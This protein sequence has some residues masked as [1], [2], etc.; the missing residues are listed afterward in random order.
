MPPTRSEWIIAKREASATRG[1][2]TAD[3][4]AAADAGL[5]V[6]REGGNAV[7]AAVTAAF[8]MGVAEPFTSG[9][10]GVACMVI[11]LPDGRSTV[12]DGSG[13]APRSARPDM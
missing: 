13:L 12:I 1:M 11:R 4:P 7:D 10:G 8:V 5:A 2:V 3:H 9:I 6:L